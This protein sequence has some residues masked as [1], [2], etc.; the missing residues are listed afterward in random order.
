MELFF[1][2]MFY[3]LRIENYE[4]RGGELNKTSGQK[5]NQ[6]MLMDLS[7]EGKYRKGGW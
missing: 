5:D 6:R 7:K 4:G 3:A 2:L 1:Y